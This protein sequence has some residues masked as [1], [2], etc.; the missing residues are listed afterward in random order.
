MSQPP[1]VGGRSDA[2]SCKEV[3]QPGRGGAARGKARWCARTQP[4]VLL[5]VC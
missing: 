1:G 4:H 2:G 5:L 3:D